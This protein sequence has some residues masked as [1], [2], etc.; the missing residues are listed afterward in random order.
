MKSKNCLNDQLC[1][2]FFSPSFLISICIRCKLCRLL[3]AYVWKTK[4]L[5]P[6]L[7]LTLFLSLCFPLDFKKE[8]RASRLMCKLIGGRPWDFR[9]FALPLFCPRAESRTKEEN[10][11]QYTQ[12]KTKQNKNRNRNLIKEPN[13]FRVY[14]SDDVIGWRENVWREK[15]DG[16]QVGRKEHVEE[17]QVEECR[18][19]VVVAVV[20]CTFRSFQRNRS[21]IHNV[22]MVAVKVTREVIARL[23]QHEPV[24]QCYTGYQI[25]GKTYQKFFPLIF[26]TESGH[27]D[28]CFFTCNISLLFFFFD[29]I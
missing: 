19:V 5:F 2:C 27:F 1:H 13:T 26:T 11:N 16:N 9:L 14:L 25:S 29:L 10:T 6:T 21:E 3:L 24:D 23:H 18:V 4:H 8:K 7:S 20:A 22:E 15:K 17:E 12:N 28:S